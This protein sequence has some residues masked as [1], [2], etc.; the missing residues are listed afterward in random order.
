M[1]TT[2]LNDA[3]SKLGL[4]NATIQHDRFFRSDEPPANVVFQSSQIVEPKYDHSQSENVI[5]PFKMDNP[6]VF[7]KSELLKWQET[8]MKQLLDYYKK[9]LDQID[10]IVDGNK[11]AINK[12]DMIIKRKHFYYCYLTSLINSPLNAGFKNLN[13]LIS[14]R[15]LFINHNFKINKLIYTYF[16]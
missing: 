6:M 15:K 2:P 1:Q 8:N 14:L 3:L 11:S 5:F 4:G 16:H 9:Q 10:R 12:A 13:Q 7:T